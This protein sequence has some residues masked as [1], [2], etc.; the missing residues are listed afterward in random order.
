[1]HNL[2]CAFGANE[3]N[4]V[5]LYNNAKEIWDKLEVTHEGTSR[6]EES[7]ISLL[8]LDYEFFKAKL[9]EGIKEMSD[10]F[11]H[12]INGLKALGKIYPNKEMV[13]KML[14]SLPM[15]WEAKVTIIEE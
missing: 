15:F 11:N 14:N 7:K 10:H 1:M 6:A 13:K 5:S 4:R 2:F 9:E 12:T 3:Y 8:T